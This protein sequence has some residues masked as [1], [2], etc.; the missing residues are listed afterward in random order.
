MRNIPRSSRCL[1]F[2]LGAVGLLSSPPAARTAERHYLIIFASQSHPKVPRLTH[3]FAT[4]VRVTDGP[5]G[6]APWIEAYTIS[7]LPQTLKIRP[8]RLHDEPDRNLSLQETLCWAYGHHMHVSEWGPYA[9]EPDFF[10]RVYGEYARIESGAFP[11][12]AIDSRQRGARTT[13]CIHALTDVDGADGRSTFS[14]FRSGDA[15]TSK[16]V[17]LMHDRGRLLDPLADMSWLETA[18]GLDCYP[19]LHRPNP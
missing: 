18:L 5:P 12:K 2:V 1:L 17:R 13:D 4:L 9:I 7:W 11:Y 6:C 14:E 19:I 10:Q 15:A 16:F 8:Y 3:I